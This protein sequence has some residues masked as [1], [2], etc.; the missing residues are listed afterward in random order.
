MNMTKC[1]ICERHINEFSRLRI[2]A[3]GLPVMAPEYA[4]V[5]QAE[6]K[7]HAHLVACH[8][9]QPEP[10]EYIQD[11]FRVITTVSGVTRRLPLREGVTA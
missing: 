1:E 9:V 2:A 5:L 7:Y 3:W 11:G 6:R 8:G 4:A 10:P